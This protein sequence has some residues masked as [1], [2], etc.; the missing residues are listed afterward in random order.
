MLQALWKKAAETTEKKVTMSEVEVCI[1]K[2]AWE[3]GL[4][5]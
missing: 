5:R 3:L 4:E 2:E 1:R